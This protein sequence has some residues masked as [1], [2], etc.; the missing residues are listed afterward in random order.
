M[1]DSLN[2]TAKG[3]C[4]NLWVGLDGNLRK[5]SAELNLTGVASSLRIAIRFESE[6]VVPCLRGSLIG[7]VQKTVFILLVLS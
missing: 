4:E 1:G 5:D 6:W 7:R 2:I 3:Y